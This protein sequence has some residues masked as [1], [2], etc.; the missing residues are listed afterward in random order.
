[1]FNQRLKGLF[2]LSL[3]DPNILFG[4]LLHFDW[5]SLSFDQKAIY[6][7]SFQLGYLSSG[8]KSKCVKTYY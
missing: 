4:G 6:V 1:M 2:I 5:G 3:G 8:W 7:S